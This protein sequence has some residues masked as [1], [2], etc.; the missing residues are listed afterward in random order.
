MFF[1]GLGLGLGDFDVNN[2]FQG[3]NPI[4]LFGDKG[5][6]TARPTRPGLGLGLSRLPCRTD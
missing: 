5:V 2:S 3:S 6:S 1:L 4:P